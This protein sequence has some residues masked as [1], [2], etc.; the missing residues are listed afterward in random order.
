MNPN[1]FWNIITLSFDII[2]KYLYRCIG[3]L[4]AQWYTI[5]LILKTTFQLIYTHVTHCGW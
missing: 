2:M 1:I 3:S 5:D 4:K